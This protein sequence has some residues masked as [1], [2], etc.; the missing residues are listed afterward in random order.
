TARANLV[1]HIQDSTIRSYWEDEFNTFDRNEKARRAGMIINKINEFITNP[2]FRRIVG[3]SRTTIEVSEAMNNGKIL[4]VKLPG[5]FE[6]MTEIL[7]AMLIAQMLAASYAREKQQK[8]RQFNIYADEFQRFATP[9]FAKLLTEASRKYNTPVTIA[10]QA[11]DFLDL[12]NQAASM[13]VTNIIIFKVTFKDAEKELAGQFDTTPP[14]PQQEEIGK[15]AVITYKRD[16]V[17][18]LLHQGHENPAVEQFINEYLQKLQRAGQQRPELNMRGGIAGK[19]VVYG[20]NTEVRTY[21]DDILPRFTNSGFLPSGKYLSN[22]KIGM[23]ERFHE[24]FDHDNF[25]VYWYDPGVIQQDLLE[26][27]TFLYDAMRGKIADAKANVYTSGFLH[28]VGHWGLSAYLG[29]DTYYYVTY[30]S[31]SPQVKE[32]YL[33]IMNAT[34]EYYQRRDV[35]LGLFGLSAFLGDEEEYQRLG[36][37]LRK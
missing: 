17:G 7:G 13:Q 16:V 9:D 18:H 36:E 10:H 26:L 29:F 21:A 15:D 5:K 12:R 32:A 3:Q 4:L 27:N 23:F 1:A 35:Q 33:Q 14:P 11:R 31:I 28:G 30:C 22:E 20:K 8:R 24:R 37:E 25:G 34:R 19:S 2:I 6:K